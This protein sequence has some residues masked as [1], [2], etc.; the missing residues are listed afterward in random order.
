MYQKHSEKEVEKQQTRKRSRGI[1]N[2]WR[3]WECVKARS[4]CGKGCWGKRL[5]EKKKKNNGM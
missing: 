5:K 3:W 4:R 1:I 2:V